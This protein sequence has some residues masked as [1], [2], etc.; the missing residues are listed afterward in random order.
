MISQAERKV[1]RREDIA[2]EFQDFLTNRWSRTAVQPLLAA[3]ML[4]CLSATI[5]LLLEAFLPGS[6]WLPFTWLILLVTLEGYMTTLW[7]RQPRQVGLD[8][9]RYRA[10][11]VVLLLLATRFATWL[12]TG[13]WPSWRL[14]GEYLRY[15]LLLFND[16]PFIIGIIVVL[17]FWQRAVYLS[18]TFTRLSLSTAEVFYYSQAKNKRDSNDRPIPMR[19][20]DIVFAFFQQWIGG[21]II[22]IFITALT[23]FDI[24]SI[25]IEA[26]FRGVT[27]LGLPPE[28]LLAL[29]LYFL[30]GFVLLSQGRLAA[31]NA[32]WLHEGVQKT[33]AVEK[34]WHRYTLWLIFGGGG[35]ALLVPLG[36]TKG[37]SAILTTILGWITYLY[38]FIFSLFLGLLSLLFGGGEETTLTDAMETLQAPQNPLPTPAPSTAA[39]PNEVAGILFSSAF[40]ALALVFGILALTFFIRERG[41][42][43]DREI[44]PSHVAQLAG[45]AARVPWGE[46]TGGQAAGCDAGT[47]AA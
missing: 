36:S 1:V 6:S 30:A 4:S 13:S 20:A 22:A 33:P 23:T 14:F 24:Q 15:P 32:K 18:E 19:R 8:H 45:L 40:W 25:D 17:I 5:F 2:P 42:K 11:E 10:S 12:V 16:L 26:G 7:L 9:T 41:V 3:V 28:L 21:G 39:P 29:I 35:L 44:R 47:A 43:W 37:I 46:R 27:R 34:S 38:T 31:M